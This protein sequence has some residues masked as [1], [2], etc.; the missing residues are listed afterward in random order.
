MK[1]ENT[2]IYNRVSTK[3]QSDNHSLKL[4][5]NECNKY[6]LENNLNIN[7]VY[8]DI[9]SGRSTNNRKEFKKMLLDLKP[10][11]LIL[12]SRVDRFYRNL[13]EG[14]EVLRTLEKKN[15]TVYAIRDKCQYPKLNKHDT[16]FTDYLRR[17]EEE[18][19]DNSKR[20][21]FTIN[22]LKE[23][24][25]SLGPP[26]FGK[27]AVFK[28]GVRTFVPNYIEISI[29]KM[30]NKYTLQGHSP[31]DIACHLNYKYIKKRGEEWST[32]MVR[33]LIKQ[34]KLKNSFTTNKLSTQLDIAQK[35]NKRKKLN[36]NDDRINKKQNRYELRTSKRKRQLVE[37]PEEHDDFIP[38]QD[39]NSDD[40]RCSSSV[41][42]DDDDEPII[43]NN[44]RRNLL[45]TSPISKKKRSRNI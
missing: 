25:Y 37:N 32:A 35:S 28:N 30:V 14:I 18:W 22:K 39:F 26:P 19:I 31:Y 20:V 15:I 21:Q 2:Y 42:S 3:S 40:S 16:K 6:A 27:K 5:L 17:S 41:S 34:F 43:V 38:D 12:I 4:Q 44:N 11:S 1:S 7:K 10:N 36:T 9:G 13:I 23:K 33:N 8:Q 24:G 45:P 29:I